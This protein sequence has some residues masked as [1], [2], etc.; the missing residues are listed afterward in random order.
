MY[1]FQNYLNSQPIYCVFN[2]IQDKVLIA[3]FY[4]VLFVDISGD[5]E[6]D[7]DNLY[8]I[9]DIR[10][11]HYYDKKFYVLANKC[12]RLLGYYLI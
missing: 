10:S 1:I 12:E 5:E 4:D 6:V 8:H 2:H 11:I 9:G 3:T 7:I